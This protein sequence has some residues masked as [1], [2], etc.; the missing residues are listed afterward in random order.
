MGTICV[1]NYA[2][3]FMGHFEKTYI[4]PSIHSF[5]N[6]YCQFIDILFLLNETVVQLQEF[7]MKHT[8]TSIQLNLT[9]NTLKPALKF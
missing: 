6:F 2:K 9:S 3:T 7:I 4:Y 1:P 8:I 5:S